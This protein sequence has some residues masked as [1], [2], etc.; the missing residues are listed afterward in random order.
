MHGRVGLVLS[1]VFL[2]NTGT[3]HWPGATSGLPL[4]KSAKTVGA[5]AT[6]QVQHPPMH[7]LLSQAG[8]SV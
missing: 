3:W 6:S 4:S 5:W 7:P 1:S 2:Q 8:R